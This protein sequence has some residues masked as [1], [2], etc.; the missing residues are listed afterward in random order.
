[1]PIKKVSDIP[2]PRDTDEFQFGKK[3]CGATYEEVPA[4]YYHWIR[5]NCTN[6]P[7]Q[8]DAYI[9]HNLMALMKEAP[10]LIWSK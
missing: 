1:M 4:S 10:D 5:H 7:P 9:D 6:V 2:I 8:V 3:Y